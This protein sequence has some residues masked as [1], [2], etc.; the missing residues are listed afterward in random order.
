MTVKPIAPSESEWRALYTAADEF[1]HWQPWRWFDDNCVF[2]VENPETHEVGYCSVM[3]ALGEVLALAVYLG[4]AGFAGL[5]NM[6]QSTPEMPD[7]DDLTSWQLCLMASFEDRAALKPE[8]LA[9]IKS[10]GL[11]FRGKQTWPLFRLFEPGHPPWAVDGSQARFLTA[12]LEQAMVVTQTFQNDPSKLLQRPGKVLVRVYQDVG[13][14]RGWASKWRTIPEHPV[15]ASSVPIPDPAFLKKMLKAADQGET[16]LESDLFYAPASIQMVKGERPTIPRMNVWIESQSGMVLDMVMEEDENFY[17]RIQ[18]FFI[19]YIREIG[20]RP[21][22]I[23]VKRRELA[24]IL[25]P[26]AVALNIEIVIT[27]HLPGVEEFRQGLRDFM[28]HP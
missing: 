26:V 24:L 19:Q 7:M 13:E 17:Q 27:P 18:Q 12:A 1:Y 23:L 8:D 10:L 28:Q 14:K 5:E 9:V 20:E 3:G 21:R 22:T 15:S 11:K 25:F 4:D 6:M 2:G 16:V